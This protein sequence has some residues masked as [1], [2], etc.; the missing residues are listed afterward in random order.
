M[1]APEKGPEP[2]PKTEV[3]PEPES[4]PKQEGKV[5][6]EKSHRIEPHPRCVSCRRNIDPEDLRPDPM[7]ERGL[8]GI[9]ANLGLTREDLAGPMADVSAQLYARGALSA[10]PGCAMCAWT[11]SPGTAGGRPGTKAA[12]ASSGRN[13][14][15]DGTGLRSFGPS[16][17]EGDREGTEP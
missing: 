6:T 8:W 12:E 4:T 7:G 13:R 1:A 3:E 11:R 10:I 16:T 15:V 5:G 17:R 14:S 9:A 2:E